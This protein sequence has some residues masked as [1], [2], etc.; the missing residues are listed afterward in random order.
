MTENDPQAGHDDAEVVPLSTGGRGD[1]T[2]DGTSGAPIDI[3]AGSI[4]D[5][6]AAAYLEDGYEDED[7][8]LDAW[9]EIAREAG[10]FLR[11]HLAE[12]RHSPSPTSMPEAGAGLHDALLAGDP[13]ATWMRRA[14][15]VAEDL[16]W[17]PGGGAIA[18]EDLLYDLV[19]ATIELREDPGLSPE[20]QASLMTLEHVDWLGAIVELVR[21]GPGTEADAD[22]LVRYSSTCPEIEDDPV[23]PDDVPVLAAGFEVALR[24][25]RVAGVV[26]RVDRFTDVG[27]W[28]LPRAACFAWG[29]DFDHPNDV[30]FADDPSGQEPGA[31]D[32]ARI[33]AELAEFHDLDVR[34]AESLSLLMTIHQGAVLGAGD[35][36]DDP[37]V[38][39]AA[40]AALGEPGV[41]AAFATEALGIG[42]QAE[43]ADGLERVAE[44]VLRHARGRR[45]AP[46]H[47]QLARVAE[48]RGE[49]EAAQ[50]ALERAL[51]LDEDLEPALEDAAWYAE[52]R[53][54]PREVLRLLRRLGVD[55]DDPQRVRMEALLAGSSPPSGTRRND[56][57]PCG[58]GRKFKV[59]CLRSPGLSVADRLGFVL[60]KLDVYVRRP[61]QRVHIMGLALTAAGS[62]ED[63]IVARLYDPMI[64]RLATFD[65]GLLAGFLRDRGPLLPAEER[66]T[67]TG[68]SD[69]RAGAYEVIDIT[70][71]EG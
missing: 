65:G 48:I 15:G 43:D 19:A 52:D 21:R 62:D 60:A 27:V 30:P 36:L 29:T 37:G 41:A 45:A 35:A 66:P 63:A 32:G 22:A 7:A 50:A 42:R 2:A 25:W 61:A 16:R 59:C 70:P 69:V 54:E 51:Q 28:L 12:H 44:I 47:Y 26:D 13:D 71:G 34:G 67:V 3:G 40:T 4:E 8:W 11:E 68:R 1:H 18:E 20:D 55:H 10:A 57:C 17:R 49:P 53:G 33:V 24:G 9:D 64:G 38:A 23:D 46:A 39:E 58:S 31:L 6:L 56:P 5:E 14:A